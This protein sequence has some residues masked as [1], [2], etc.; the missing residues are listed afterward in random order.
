MAQ[1]GKVL[2]AVV[3][4]QATLV[5][6]KSGIQHPRQ[7]ILNPPVTAHGMGKLLDIPSETRQGVAPLDGGPLTNRALRFTQAK[8]AQCWPCPGLGSPANL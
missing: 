6:A 8:A 2:R 4:A 1:H 7:S 3:A 5:F